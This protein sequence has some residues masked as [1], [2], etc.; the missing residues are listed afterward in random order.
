MSG[1]PTW[2]DDVPPYDPAA[3]AQTATARP[4]PHPRDDAGAWD[5]GT[6]A[7]NFPKAL[8]VFMRK[9]KRQRAM[10]VAALPSTVDVDLFINACRAAVVRTPEL[11]HPSYVETLLNAVAQA[12]MQGLVP[13]GHE[14]ALIKRW[15]RERR[16]DEVCWTPMVWGLAK[17]GRATGD[18]DHWVANIVWRGERFENF[19]DE[20]GHERV[21]HHRN[22]DM[23]TGDI[24]KD[25]VAAYC[26]LHTPRHGRI[27]RVMA[28]KRIL[29]VRAAATAKTGPWQGA[30]KDEMVIK[31]ILRATFKWMDRSLTDSPDLGRFRAALDVDTGHDFDRIVDE[32]ETTPGVPAARPA[33][34]PPPSRLDALRE[35]LTKGRETTVPAPRAAVRD[36]EVVTT[37]APRRAPVA[38][39]EPPALTA[40]RKRANDLIDAGTRAKGEGRLDRFWHHRTVVAKMKNLLNTYPELHDH[41]QASISKAP[42]LAGQTESNNR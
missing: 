35:T 31:T 29:A 24:D 27:V 23:Q 4:A 15:S 21:V 2:H 41:V 5:E 19:V 37:P 40:A 1:P 14:G 7:A 25:M 22:V 20:D 12:A 42:A 18:I 33:L 28:A 6:V 30:F 39:E 8:S 36:A 11:C 26:I 34:D 3:V 17:L 38:P 10:L 9:I 16:R 13:D 32:T